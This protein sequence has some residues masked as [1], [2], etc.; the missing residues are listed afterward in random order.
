MNKY[1][2]ALDYLIENI[3]M[4]NKH[5]DG[6]F[7][8][9]NYSKSVIQ[10]L[11]NKQEK[12]KWHDL[13]KDPMDVPNVGE[14]VLCATDDKGGREVQMFR[15]AR[16]YENNNGEICWSWTWEHNTE[17]SPIAWKYIE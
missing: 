9:P 17:K 14:K 12:Y 5:S 2:E 3:K 15:E 4:L 1:Q 16:I 6:A 13:R 7:C 10:E 11:I 8:E